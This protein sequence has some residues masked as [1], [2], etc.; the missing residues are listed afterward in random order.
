MITIYRCDVCYREF[1]SPEGCRDHERTHFEGNNRIKYDL[2]SAN[3]DVCDYCQKSY[4]VYG[5]ERDCDH[6]N[7]SIVNFYSD[8][9]PVEPFHNK[10]ISGV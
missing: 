10:R 1:D 7:C 3:S 4:Y 2:I 6:K 5:C 8:F 9:E